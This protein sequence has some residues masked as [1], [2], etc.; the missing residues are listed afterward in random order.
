MSSI[1]DQTYHNYLMK[2]KRLNLQ[3]LSKKIGTEWDGKRMKL[4]L[5][6]RHFWVSEKGIFN[7]SGE[8][9]SHSE[10]VV[11]ANYLIRYPDKKISHRGKWL[12]YRD[13]KDSAPLLDAF[14]NNVERKLSLYFKQNI[15]SLVKSCKN[16]DGISYGEEWGYDVGFLFNALPD[17]SVLLLF[18]D[19]DEMFPAH[20]N[21][22][23]KETI[24]HYLDMESVAILG[25]ILTDYLLS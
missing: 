3:S 25:L 13:F 22:L 5:F 7:V 17:I 18:N 4:K 24:K 20:C 2:I 15:E 9:P 14:H 21:V 1:F 16:L 8:R 11:I 23:F 10:V 6:T 12:H 19:V